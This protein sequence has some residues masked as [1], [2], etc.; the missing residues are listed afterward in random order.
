MQMIE[1]LFRSTEDGTPFHMFGPVHIALLAIS[2]L[3]LVGIVASRD[4]I[5]AHT[6]ARRTIE[7]SVGVGLLTFQ[8]LYYIWFAGTGLYTM[9]TAL[10]LYTCR[11]ASILGPIAL[12]TH[13]KPLK[14]LG[15]Y[16]GFY[17]LSTLIVPD[18]ENYAFPHITNF[19]FW[20]VH[21]LLIC[22]TAILVFWGEGYDFS[23]DDFK[24]MMLFMLVYLMISYP[25]DMAV[26]GNYHFFLQAPLALD[27]ISRLPHHLYAVI[28]I[29]MYLLITCITF[30]LGRL[31]TRRIRHRAA[32]AV[33]A[34][35]EIRIR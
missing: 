30:G 16:W 1:Y 29:C 22:M 17:A 19:I 11:V 21:M 20:G 6:R 15:V 10:P 35:Q 7:I 34:A 13:N 14:V 28:V 2:V 27:F 3:L 12:F 23:F 24:K 8:A 5:N 9:S 25:F 32:N 4:F 31:A 18:M 26:Q 33:P